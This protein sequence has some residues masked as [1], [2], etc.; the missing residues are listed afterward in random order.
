MSLFGRDVAVALV[1]DAF[2]FTTKTQEAPLVLPAYV[3]I[4]TGTKR[5]LACGAEAKAMLGK[6]P[7]N[8]SLTPN[9]RPHS[10]PLG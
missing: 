3:A 2:I 5:I 1:D 8:I 7:N 10:L 4:Q 6:E 9:A